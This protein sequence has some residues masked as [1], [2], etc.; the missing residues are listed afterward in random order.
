[1]SKHRAPLVLI[2]LSVMLRVLALASALCLQAFQWADRKSDFHAR[3][4]QGDI[5]IQNAAEAVKAA[6]G[7]MAQAAK[8]L[9][10]RA[11][12]DRFYLDYGDGYSLQ[13]VLKPDDDPFVG[14][15]ELSVYYDGQ[16]LTGLTVCWQEGAS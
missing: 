1:M 14:F 10:A 6:G 2:E 11:E 13:A 7:N 3:R 16:L 5:L 15:A 9:D 4:D 12:D 8:L